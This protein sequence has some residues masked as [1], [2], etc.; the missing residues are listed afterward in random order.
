MRQQATWGGLPLLNLIL[1]SGFWLL[2]AI[3]LGD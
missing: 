2:G 3:A 1:F